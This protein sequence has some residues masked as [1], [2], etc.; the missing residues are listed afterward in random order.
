ML[1]LLEDAR[2]PADVPVRSG[3]TIDGQGAAQD[4]R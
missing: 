4:S 1:P 3:A 2:P